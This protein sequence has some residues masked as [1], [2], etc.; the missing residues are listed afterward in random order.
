MPPGA[1]MTDPRTDTIAR[2]AARLLETGR[3]GSISHAIRTAAEALGLS[4][5]PLPGTG[6]VRKH[7]QAMS[8]QA[9]GDDCYAES[10]RAVW[11]VAEEIMTALEQGLPDAEPRLMGRG[12]KGQIDGGVVLYI[13]LHTRAAIGEV[14][15]ALVEFGY[16]E[17]GFE[18]ADTR[19]GRFDRV[20]MDVD[21]QEV[22]IT[23]CM[24]EMLYK[25][26]VDLFHKRPVESLTL[27]EL[28]DRLGS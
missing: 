20:R 18:T 7:V 9:L 6:R 17:P 25:A 8:M 28:R 10:I 27:P 12:A 24:P 5:A 15:R 11:R 3:A 22:V 26:G 1:A 21:G 14:A 16:D 4:G 19:F 13:R 2:E 23:R